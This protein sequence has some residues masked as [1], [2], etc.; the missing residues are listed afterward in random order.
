M[1]KSR[2]LRFVAYAAAGVLGAVCLIAVIVVIAAGSDWG[3]SWVATAMEQAASTSD[4]QRLGLGRIEGNL[5]GAFSIDEIIFGDKDGDWLSIRSLAVSWSPAALLRGELD[6]LSLTAERVHVRRAPVTPPPAEDTAAAPLDLSLPIGIS[7]D[8][9]EVAAVD[10][11]PAV[12]GE[13]IEFAVQG[14]AQVPLGSLIDVAFDIK[15]RKPATK[16]ARLAL[17]YDPSAETLKVDVAYDE[18]AGGLVSR[19]LKADGLSPVSLRIAGEGPVVDWNGTVSGIVPGAGSVDAAINLAREDGLAFKVTG[20]GKYLGEDP[21]QAIRLAGQKLDFSVAGTWR[22]DEILVVESARAETSAARVDASGQLAVAPQTLEARARA[23]VKDRSLYG[24]LVPDLDIGSLAVDVTANGKVSNPR[25]RLEA[26]ADDVKTS[27]AS[28]VQVT[29]EVDVELRQRADGSVDLGPVKVDGRMTGAAFPGMPDLQDLVGETIQWKSVGAGGG[30]DAFNIK[31]MRVSAKAVDASVDGKVALDTGDADLTAVLKVSD[32]AGVGVLAGMPMSGSAMIRTP[33][34]VKAF[35]NA[36][37]ANLSGKIA[38]LQLDDPALRALVGGDTAIKA[39]I[40]YSKESLT[41]SDAV[42][43]SIGARLTAAAKVT[44][45]FATLD[46]DYELEIKK[47]DAVAAA[48]DAP[49]RASPVRVKGVVSGP[50]ANPGTKGRLLVDRVDVDG[51]VINDV[52]VA[53]QVTEMVEAAAGKIDIRAKMPA[54]DTNASTTFKMEKNDLHVTAFTLKGA[55]ITGNG[56]AVVP[57]DGTPVRGDLKLDMRALRPWFALAGVSGNAAGTVRLGLSEKGGKQAAALVTR[58]RDISLTQP[59][60]TVV[61]VAS[62][63]LDAKSSDLLEKQTGTVTLRVKDVKAPEGSIARAEVKAAGTP[64]R[65]DVD[66]SATGAWHGDLSMTLR[67]QVERTPGRVRSHLTRLTGTALGRPVKLNKPLVVDLGEKGIKVDTL[68]LGFGEGRITAS[69]NAGSDRL[70]AAA[71][72]RAF[73]L[74]VLR[75][76]LDTDI[77]GSLDGDV[78]IG[79]PLAKLSGTGKM[80]GNGIRLASAPKEQTLTVTA[81]ADWKDNR[82]AVDGTISASKSLQAAVRANVP[83]R[84]DPATKA[85]D[86]PAAEKISGEAVWRGDIAEVWPYLPLDMHRLA[87]D[88]SVDIRLAGT[89]G[90]PQVDGKVTLAKGRYE[91]LLSGTVL[92]DL[93]IDVV[94]AGDRVKIEQFSATDGGKGSLEITGGATVDPKQ[95]FPFDVRTTLNDFTLVRR[96]DVIAAASADIT[97]SGTAEKSKVAGTV[98]TTGV[99]IQ[100]IDQLPPTVVELDVTEINGPASTRVVSADRRATGPTPHV[101]LDVLVQMPRRVFVRGRGLDSEWGGTIKVS[102]TAAEPKADG[103][104]KLVRGQV[105]VV[106]KTF[107]LDSGTVT[108]PPGDEISPEIDVVAIHSG[109]NLET[110]VQIAGPVANPEITFSSVPDLPQDEIIAKMLFNKSAAGLSP[111]EAVQLAAALAELTGGGGGGVTD[112]ARKTLGVDVLRVDSDDTESDA[113]PALNV[114]KYVTDGVYVGVKQGIT[115]ESSSVSVEVEIT[116]NISVDSNVRQNGASE[117]GVKFKL[118]Y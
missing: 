46:A 84:F 40:D 10:L 75:P 25:I 32:L 102:G 117:T 115:P 60:Q 22:D 21:P 63:V 85:L 29:T 17:R 81:T 19:L 27:G 66:A 8:R 74:G 57:L 24:Q 104:L 6:V 95:A 38:G 77:A 28:A 89:V 68:D 31:E 111:I 16:G 53:Y 69:A 34:T 109:V 20:V 18:A 48:V 54:G 98:T 7:L 51:A 9:V 3:R 65:V 70:T 110:T 30:R 82:A 15:E 118:D 87:G 36:A 2:L 80:T 56:K 37:Q 43:D 76:F 58:L 35:G 114:G 50:T 11:E 105:S 39:K 72:L 79:G 71:S 1:P 52:S 94:L 97:L 100:L 23:V 42:I 86:L 78:K 14:S 13:R 92:G 45:A 96:D 106:G 101:D 55:G 90:T 59:D 67:G 4:E 99:E 12:L 83:L 116:P 47:P 113:S 64:A 73:P 91:N 108:L 26:I 107:K 5:L 88:S 93:T 41:V 61:S 103:K 44:G 33:I 62:L 112:F 49:V